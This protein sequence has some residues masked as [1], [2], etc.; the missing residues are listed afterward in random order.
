[1]QLRRNALAMFIIAILTLIPMGQ[2]RVT[3]LA[4][5]LAAPTLLATIPNVG[6]V[7][8]G[9]VV[10]E[11]HNYI[12][13][14]AMAGNHLTRINGATLTVDKYSPTSGVVV[15]PMGLAVN[16]ANQ[17]V[18]ACNN[19]ANIPHFSIVDGNTMGLVAGVYVGAPQMDVAFNASL[20]HA[21]A[22]D[23]NKARVYA[24]N[25]ASQTK[26]GDILNLAN[27][28]TKIALS[29]DGR[30]AYVTC[31]SSSSV[32]VIDTANRVLIARFFAHYMNPV[33]IAVNPTNGYIYVANVGDTTT[34][35]TRAGYVTVVDDRNVLKQTIEVGGFW[36]DGHGVMGVAYNPNTDHLFVS[37]RGTPGHVLVYKG[38]PPYNYITTIQVGNN[39]DA[40]ITVDQTRNR[41]YVTN[42]GSNTVSV[43]QDTATSAASVPPATYPPDEEAVMTTPPDEPSPL[44]C[45]QTTTTNITV[46]ITPQG[47]AVDDPHGKAYVANN[48]AGTVSRV[49]LATNTQEATS[50]TSIVFGP[51]AVA[52]NT[53]VQ[54][55]YVANSASGYKSVSILNGTD[56]SLLAYISSVG[57]LETPRHIY[58]VPDADGADRL[59][60]ANYDPADTSKS[61]VT[62]ISLTS[63]MNPTFRKFSVGKAP[64]AVALSADR[65]VAYVA[66]HDSI[67][68]GGAYLSVVDLALGR[69]VAQF[70]THYSQPTDIIL[71]PA[72][73][74]LYVANEG[75]G[76]VVA[77][78]HRN[79][80]KGSVTLGDKPQGLSLNPNFRRLAVIKK[81]TEIT[82]FISADSFTEICL[83]VSTPQA[84]RWIAF[85]SYYNRF[86][87]SASSGLQVMVIQDY[88]G[89]GYE[90]DDSDSLAK[91][92]LNNTPQT[93]TIDPA[94][95]VDWVKFQVSAPVTLTLSATPGLTTTLSLYDTNGTTP[96]VTDTNPLVYPFT[97]SGTYYARVKATDPAMGGPAYAYQ[98]LLSGGSPPYRLYLPLISRAED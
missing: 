16:P 89:D 38:S 78:D 27:N 37:R 22:T 4:A 47:I 68:Y 55:V 17:Q 90:N 86:Y 8:T 54:R 23:F 12:Y 15:T 1:M 13:V 46:G 28:P 84:D 29:P 50:S 2:L 69:E 88:L 71:D 72:R 82:S 41:V 97:A 96:L 30:V 51:S 25:T 9:V 92:I 7:P 52:V 43:I 77:V 85:S 63:T 83:P 3:A 5:P 67:A 87:V 11:V 35:K 24:V 20:N 75:S 57:Y 45:P 62:E 14:S 81:N 74:R 33:G 19:G 79:L 70:F 32:D 93:H 80:L 53:S 26:T 76:K 31:V 64:Y 98:L 10:D 58:L 6:S 94:G 95:D 36:T 59:Y 40:F 61:Y 66:C 49:N 48:V 42:Q 73:D 91:P 44:P 39:P 56:L 18:Y 34:S 21:F 60:V 65:A